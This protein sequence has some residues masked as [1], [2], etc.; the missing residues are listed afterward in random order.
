MKVVKKKGEGGFTDLVCTVS[1][2]EVSN[3]L[4]QAIFAFCTQMGIRPQSG[5]TPE[6]AVA[7]QLGIKNLDEVVTP[8]AV[9]LMVPKAIDKSGF[10]PAF[11][12]QAQPITRFERGH[13]FQFELH[14]YPKPSFDLSSY[15]PVDITVE[16]YIPDEA[17]IDQ[18]IA[19]MAQA[20]TNFVAIDPKP[21]ESGDSCLLKMVTIKDGEEVPGLTADER[22]YTLGEDLMPPGFDEALMGMEVGETREFTFQ[23]PG[24]DDQ[25]NEIME[26][27]DCTITLLEVQKEIV[28]VIDDEWVKKNMPMYKDLADM[29]EKLGREVDKQRHQIYED[30]VRN[31]AAGELSKR[32]EGTIPD[33]VYEGTA[34]ETQKR[35]RMQVA[36]QG[37]TWEQFIEQNGGEQQ[38]NMMLMIETRQQLVVGYSLDAYYRHEKLSFT[39]ADLDEV[40]AQMNPQNPKMAR[41]SMEKSGFGYALRESAERLCACKALVESANITYTE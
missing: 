25:M 23:G 16:P 15:G 2:E 7:E 11:M 34:V 32:F 9:E 33:P 6:Q 17:A 20:F 36:Q 10:I 35:I 31:V 22:N 30:Y 28:P 40:C 14:L 26:D 8:Q 4:Q 18:Q 37:L 29:R 24:L 3:Y 39:D 13:A 5:I 38:A 27:Y 19:G 41:E 12:P 1:S 21:L